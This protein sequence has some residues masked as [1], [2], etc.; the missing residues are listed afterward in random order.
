MGQDMT[1]IGYTQV[2]DTSERS[3]WVSAFGE[4][5][6]ILIGPP[7]AGTS[8]LDAVF[9]QHPD[10]YMSPIKEPKHFLSLSPPP[11]RGGPG[12]AQAFGNYVWNVRD[13]H[14]LFFG[15][16][17]HLLRG[18]STPYYLSSATAHANMAKRV[19]DAKLIAL[20]RDPAR[21][22]FSHWNYSRANGTEPLRDFRAACE[23][24]PE[25]L[26]RGWAPDWGYLELSR[27]GK[28]FSSLFRHFSPNQVLCLTQEELVASP[29]ETMDRVWR[30]LDVSPVTI[31]L[32]WENRTP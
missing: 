29:S 10:L 22:A 1:A 12:D 2:S 31:D 19:P 11:K 3:R 18:E 6:F 26:S 5:D 7:K 20:L 24:E 32:P 25:R 21:R 13:Y 8:S 30:F 23:A 14:S 17:E 28:H 4:P 27:Y 15:A 16:P 9:R